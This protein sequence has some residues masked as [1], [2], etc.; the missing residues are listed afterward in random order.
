MNIIPIGNRIIVRKSS[1]ETTTKGGIV[2][3][4]GS[5]PGANCWAE[6]IALPASENPNISQMKLGG[7]ILYRRFDAD[8]G[9]NKDENFEVVEVEPADGSRQ[10]Q[11]LAYE[12]PQENEKKENV[13]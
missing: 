12:P 4:E 11:V 6:I 2:I 7:K 5:A 3:A 8:K 1:N 13:S 10:G 9:S